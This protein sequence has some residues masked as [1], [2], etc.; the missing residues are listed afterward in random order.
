MFEG[1]HGRQDPSKPREGKADRDKGQVVRPWRKQKRCADI[2]G[3]GGEGRDWRHDTPER[4]AT[5]C[6]S[7]SLPLTGIGTL[8]A[9]QNLHS[10]VIVSGKR[11][12]RQEGEREAVIR[13]HNETGF[14]QC[15]MR[16]TE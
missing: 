15:S 5:T 1:F 14:C 8:S 16:Y 13:G 11:D 10:L 3:K 4:L 12:I 2:L 6:V 7:R 9:T